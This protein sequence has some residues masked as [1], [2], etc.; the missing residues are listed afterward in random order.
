MGVMHR[1]AAERGALF[2]CTLAAGWHRAVETLAKIEM[3]IDVSIEMV[4]A[5]KPGSRADE[6]AAGEPLRAV[7]AIWSAVIRWNL[8][9]AVWANR[10]LSNIYRN[11]R[12]GL[13]SG[14]YEKAHRDGHQCHSF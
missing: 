6:N 11:L 1:L 3:M 14:R 2:C 5:V 8:V 7:I 13:V 10:G 4:G 9:V 12:V